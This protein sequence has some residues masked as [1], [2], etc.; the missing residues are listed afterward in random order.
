MKRADLLVILAHP[1]DETLHCG[2]LLHRAARNGEV[3]VTVTLTRGG[4]GRT[5]GMCT[6][7]ELPS[8]REQELRRAAEALGIGCAEVHDLPDG[9][10]SA[11][12]ETGTALISDALRRWRPRRVVGFPPN[13][14]NGHPDHRAAHRIA[15]AALR[16]YDGHPQVLLMT[17]AVPYTEPARPGFMDPEQVEAERLSP[18]LS[19]QVSDSLA[20]K[21][22]AMG[23]YETQARSVA[24]FLRLYPER[25]YSEAFHQIGG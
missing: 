19:M 8:V 25:F 22:R 13:G 14:M 3:T 12:E 2:G 20:A 15:V 21:L 5:L 16:A 6:T 4:A 1:D 24:K 17:S 11:H 9:G 7:G 18:T 23:H 10:L